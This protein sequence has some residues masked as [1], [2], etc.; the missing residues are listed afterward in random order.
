MHMAWSSF[1]IIEMLFWKGYGT[2]CPL[3]LTY[4]MR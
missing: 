1:G 2:H 4:E 3:Y